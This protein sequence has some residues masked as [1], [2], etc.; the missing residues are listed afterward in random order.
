[1]P[2]ALLAGLL[3]TAACAETFDNVAA[4]EDWLDAAAFQACGEVDPST[5]VDCAIYED[6]RICDVSDYFTCLSDSY[7][8][9]TGGE[10]P[11]AAWD[12][13]GC[14]PLATCE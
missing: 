1:M 7:T 5:V 11:V 13:Q 8:C 2:R 10:T 9:D 14:A 3:L 12:A 4:C 6:V